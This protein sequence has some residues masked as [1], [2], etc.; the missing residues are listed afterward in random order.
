MNR[1]V[2]AGVMLAGFG[3][4]WGS[5]VRAE[6]TGWYF[7]LS[8][9]LTA[10][11][12]SAGDIDDDIVGGIAAGLAEEDLILS[13]AAVDSD[14]DDTDKG[15]GVHIGYRITRYVAV[16]VGFIDLGEFFYENAMAL[17]VDDGP[18]GFPAQTI[19]AAS[20]LRLT[21]SG[22]FASVLGMLPI[23]DAF[24]IHARG[25][26]IF[27]DTRARARSIVEDDPD[28]FSSFEAK[29]RSRDFFAGIGASWNIN[30]SYSLRF[31]YQKFLDVG[32]DDTGEADADY[33]NFAILFR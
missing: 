12:E 30:P 8:G 4:I 22:P 24:D 31:E 26:L 21:S 27:A 29:D 23:T 6:D 25:G 11:S 16:E 19:D 5:G 3:L 13:A 17:T 18:G 9:G 15:W 14:L 10:T 2:T 28:T 7:G 33:I 20:D 32:D 1:R